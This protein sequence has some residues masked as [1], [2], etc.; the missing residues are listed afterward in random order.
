MFVNIFL[1][2][3]DKDGIS[4]LQQEYPEPPSNSFFQS[5]DYNT[6]PYT[7]LL[8]SA[9]TIFIIWMG[10]S[11]LFR[12]LF[13]FSGRG[14]RSLAIKELLDRMINISIAPIWSHWKRIQNPVEINIR[15]NVSL[16]LMSLFFFFLFCGLEAVVIF[17]QSSAFRFVELDKLGLKTNTFTPPLEKQNLSL[18][19][20]CSPLV[21]QMPMSDIIPLYLCLSSDIIQFSPTNNDQEF[22]VYLNNTDTHLQVVLPEDSDYAMRFHFSIQLHDKLSST[23]YFANM[24]SWGVN[25]SGENLKWLSAALKDKYGDKTKISKAQHSGMLSIS[26]PVKESKDKI[27]NFIVSHIL[28]LFHISDNDLKGE[29]FLAAD[30]Q[31]SQNII[32]IV[33]KTRTRVKRL[34]GTILWIMVICLAL[35]KLLLDFFT[36]DID[37][38]LDQ[39]VADVLNISPAK[40][41]ILGPNVPF[42]IVD[43]YDPTAKNPEVE[44]V[45]RDG[46]DDFMFGLSLKHKT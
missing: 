37:N 45:V 17:S 32:G 6:K 27:Q 2:I 22:R 3:D 19:S 29:Q 9:A 39:M 21:K 28:R 14:T 42:E 7:D 11:I 34:S 41:L 36:W 15:S 30:P 24:T 12:L 31:N 33:A 44:E 25:V 38:D 35:A 40:C 43:A 46:S 4:R 10:T 1:Q 16:R 23:T 18:R 5:F 20:G 13:A 8:D 26:V